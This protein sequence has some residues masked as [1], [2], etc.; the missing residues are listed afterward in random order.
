MTAIKKFFRAIFWLL[1][2]PFR[3][4]IW[5]FKATV[6]KIRYLKDHIKYQRHVEEC[7][8]LK[9]CPTCG[10]DI[11]TGVCYKCRDTRYAAERKRKEEI[12]AKLRGQS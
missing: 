4:A 6:R 5:P 8:E 9:I 1:M 12:R 3:I 2:L 11:P 10:E 7:Y